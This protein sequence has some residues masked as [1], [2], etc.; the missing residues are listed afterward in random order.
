MTMSTGVLV[1]VVLGLMTRVLVL[2]R[3]CHRAVREV[4][5]IR[6]ENE[7]MALTRAP[8]RQRPRFGGRANRGQL[9][10]DRFDPDQFDWVLFNE[11]L[12]GG[13]PGGLRL[14]SLRPLNIRSS[15]GTSFSGASFL[16]DQRGRAT[17]HP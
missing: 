15:S 3:R 11:V 2:R 8:A 16:G 4:R 5:T 13:Q 1:L 12:N 9:D 14:R 10:L 7:A 6:H 17:R